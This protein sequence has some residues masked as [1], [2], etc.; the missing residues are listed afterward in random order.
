MSPTELTAIIT[1]VTAAIASVIVPLYL[2]HQAARQAAAGGA[3]ISWQSITKVLQEERDALRKE[4][5]TTEAKH[6]RELQ[7]LDADYQAQLTE[8][9]ARITHLETEVADLYRRLYQR[10]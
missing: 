4:L 1:A 6:R 10:P 2:Q 3:I 9:R 8:A 7:E 5:D